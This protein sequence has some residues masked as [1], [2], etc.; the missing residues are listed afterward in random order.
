M[1]VAAV[2]A[3]PALI[4]APAAG[5]DPEDHVPYCSAG[6]DPVNSNCRPAPNQENSGGGAPGANPDLPTGVNPGV[7][8]AV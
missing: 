2:L 4:G 8:P 6:Q 5:A 1:L 7:A 3:L